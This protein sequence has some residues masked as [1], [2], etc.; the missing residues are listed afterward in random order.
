MRFRLWSMA[1][2][3]VSVAG[4]SLAYTARPRRR[5]DWPALAWLAVLSVLLIWYYDPE[6]LF[7]LYK[8]RA[9]TFGVDGALAAWERPVVLADRLAL[10]LI[11]LTLCHAIRRLLR[12][13][14]QAT[15]LQ[16]RAQ[17]L[18]V[19]V[20]H[21]LLA[22]FFVVLFCSGP[23]RVLNAEAMAATLLPAAGYPVFDTTYLVAVPFAGLAV[24][25][26]V[27]LSM[28]RFGFLGTWH[29]GTRELEKQINVAN[30][31]VRL[32]LHSFKN[33]FLAVQMA[34]DLAAL[35]LEGEQGDGV[36]RAG[37]R[38]NEARDVCRD[39]LAQLDVL[40]VQA[41]R[42]QVSPGVW[43]WQ[44][45]WEEASHR[46]TE[47]SDTP[48]VSV[49]STTQPVHVWADREHL[50]SAL[51]NLLQNALEALGDSGAKDRAPAV[52][53]EIGAEY[54]WGYV[55]ITDNGPGIAREHL[56]RV[57]RPFYTTKPSKSNWGMGLAYCHRV[58]K[59][60]RGF[61]NLRSRPGKGTMVEVVLRCRENLDAIPDPPRPS[62]PFD[63]KT[64]A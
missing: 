11:A 26:V 33:R 42:L 62:T 57:F 56:R 14:R 10:V 8:A 64:S 53:V 25:G 45:L 36:R 2:F 55:R 46:C 19:A 16:K 40:H 52:E 28:L 51:E 29:V 13:W 59:A 22:F 4:F 31:A 34:M 18:C 41:G 9:N 23:A 63:E 44:E 17:A 21:G 5:I 7:T 35:Q 61:I 49:R 43:S 3:I 32:A 20:G 27:L 60:H 39:A 58:I 15:I 50:V 1:G 54:E 37:A 30:Q 24:A 47:R 12:L 38:I 48:I 6:H